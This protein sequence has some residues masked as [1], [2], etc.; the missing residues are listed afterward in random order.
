VITAQEFLNILGHTE[1]D[2]LTDRWGNDGRAMGRFQVHPSWVWQYAHRYQVV[3]RL[4]VT[5]DQWVAQLVGLFFDEYSRS[6][7]PIEVA[8]HFH[9]GHVCGLNDGDW[10]LEYAA[11]FVRWANMLGLVVM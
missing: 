5:W 1:S 3:P 8:M 7:R 10:D 2:G 6:S 9:R 4:D 11:R